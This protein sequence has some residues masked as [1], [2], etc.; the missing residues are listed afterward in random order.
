[1][2]GLLTDDIDMDDLFES[3][4]SED[5]D[6]SH[7]GDYQDEYIG[8]E[9]PHGLGVDDS[10]DPGNPLTWDAFDTGFP[11]LEGLDT[12]I[13]NPQVDPDDVAQQLEQLAAE[14]DNVAITWPNVH[15]V[16]MV[17]PISST[18]YSMNYNLA[19][20]LQ[21]W[22]SQRRGDHLGPLGNQVLGK[23]RGR[24]PWRRKVE[25]QCDTHLTHVQYADLE[26]DQCDFQGIDWEDLGVTRRDARERRLLTYKNYVNMENS[27]RWHPQLPDIIIPRTESFFRFRR[28]DIRRNITLSHFQL[29]N[30]LA[31]SSRSHAFYTGSDVVHMFN[32][33][34]GEG[35]PVLKFEESQGAHF[36]TLAADHGVVVGGGFSGEYIFRRIDSGEDEKTACHEGIITTNYQSGIT[37]HVQIHLS[38]R[39]SS[40]Q[41]AFSSNDHRFRVLDLETET[42]VSEEAFPYALN[43][44]VLSPDRRLRVVVGDHDEVLITA[45]E[46]TR[47]SGQPEILQTLSGHR[48]FGFACDWA[49]DGWTVATGFQDKA[50]KIWDARRFTDSKGD[51]TPV[52]TLRAEMASVRSLRFSP[53]GS[54][55]PVLVAAEEADFI[56]IIDAQTF[57]SK[58]TVDFFGEIGGI[59]FTND[60]QDL[61]VL[62]CDRMRPGLIQLERCGLG[63]ETSWD[64]Y[65]E[66]LR[67]RDSMW[68]RSPHF[69][70]PQSIFNEKKRFIES[71]SKRRRKAV[72]L[73]AVEPF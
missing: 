27:D 60:G 68:R 35:K 7:T 1:M 15:P 64:P 30:I 11:P 37:N 65:E 52:C 69:D 22:A 9:G 16:A 24:I 18:L 3:T 12:V 25:A 8:A 44:S 72:G 33:L 41:A 2:A 47:G 20:F 58:Q 21:I 13:Q 49:D 63:A 26:G 46:S 4:S 40:P 38:R 28:M 56:N 70:W 66:P 53:I 67:S 5:L 59:S 51:A 14:D 10:S 61:M 48:D 50:V 19:D 36:S 17:S 55:K 57:R 71:E 23:E 54:G 29:R 31:C 42:F 6:F 43:C 45:A 34:S 62:C 39:S 73:D 32:P